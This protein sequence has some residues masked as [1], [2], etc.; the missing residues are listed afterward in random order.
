[1]P[2]A[3]NKD[4]RPIR[5][6]TLQGPRE[7]YVIPEQHSV[8]LLVIY[9]NTSSCSS[10][11]FVFSRRGLF[12]RRLFRLQMVRDEVYIVL[13][14]CWASEMDFSFFQHPPTPFVLSSSSNPHHHHQPHMGIPWIR[15]CCCCVVGTV[16]SGPLMSAKLIEKVTFVVAQH[17]PIKWWCPAEMVILFRYTY[18]S[19]CCCCLWL[20]VGG[21]AYRQVR[22][23]II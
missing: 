20:R 18:Y 17:N 2:Q 21:T 13:I 5:E 9:C 19:C 15:S 3:K 12:S 16:L 1:M 6:R 8:Y 4:R 11:P 10:S 14:Y 23:R 7:I 22:T